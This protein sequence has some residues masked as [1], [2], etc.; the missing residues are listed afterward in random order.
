MVQKAKGE[1]GIPLTTNNPF[2]YRKDPEDRKVGRGRS[3]LVVKRIFKLYGSTNTQIVKLAGG[4]GANPIAYK[5]REGINTSSP[6][7]DDPYHWNPNSVVHI[8]NG[9][10]HRL[11]G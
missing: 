8:L 10:I 2:G 5:R 1:Q 9:G 6:E 3:S 11:Y 4:T 7:T